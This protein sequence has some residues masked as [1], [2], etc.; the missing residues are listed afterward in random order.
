MSQKP[1]IIFIQNDHQAFY[2]W[3][4]NDGPKPM[5]P[6]FDQL[7]KEGAMFDHAYCSTPLCGP[8]R[9]TMLTG[10]YAHTH[11]QHHN[12]TDPP[13]NHEVYLDTL[14]EAGYDN[15]YF[16]KW[17]AGPGAANEHHCSGF[18]RTDYS[19]PYIQPEYKAYLER[20]NL[21]QAVHHIDRYF[22]IPEISIRGDWAECADDVDYQC[23]ANWCGEHAVGIT[24]TPKETHES[25]FLATLACEQL[26][27]LAKEK[28][29]KPFSLRVDFWGPHQPHFP[30]QEF[31]DMYPA[32]SFDLPEYGNFR[33]QLEGKPETYFRER[34]TPFGKDNE[35]IIPSP[36][37]WDEWKE[38]IR[39]CFAHITMID[40]AGGMIL[41]KLKE[42]GLDENTMIIWTTDHGDALASHGGHFDKGSF[43]SEEVMRIPFAIKWKDVIP[44]G[45]VRHEYINT[46]DYPVTILDA[47]GTKFTKNKV[48]GR[49]LLPL[50][51]GKSTEWDDDVMS[52]TFGHGYGDDI[53]CRLV[54]HDEY[55]LV[56]T[57]GQKAELYNLREDPYELHNRIDDEEYKEIKEDLIK[58]LRAWQVRTDDPVE[59]L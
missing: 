23:K 37:S 57:K 13:Y 54:V 15:Y 24:K 50:V 59:V 5:R 41:N 47:A 53:D 31:L 21:P 46:V 14:A 12:Y 44:A 7:A 2:R 42:L 28:S 58:R 55:K 26:E 43:L 20:Y 34:S 19:N 33:S 30:T 27:K 38:I 18:S 16:G 29:D 39:H 6:N 11:G 3:Q 56:V 4:W 25:F 52:E 45:Q 35:L 48:H 49:S 8:T 9:R 36:V 1:N 17:H 10:L 40:A 32:E 22:D 51:T